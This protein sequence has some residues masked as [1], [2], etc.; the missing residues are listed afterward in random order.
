MKAMFLNK[1][2]G[3]EA[4]GYGEIPQP[5]SGAGQVLVKIFAT[6]ITPTELQWVTTWKQRGAP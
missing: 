2:S 5:W 1:V 6:A 3:P 4:L